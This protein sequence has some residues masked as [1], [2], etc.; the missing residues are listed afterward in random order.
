MLLELAGVVGCLGLVG[1]AVALALWFLLAL[2]AVVFV[3]S[4]AT[5]LVSCVA[6]GLALHPNRPRATGRAQV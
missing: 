4:L 1:S 3:A 5:L 2:P 6:V